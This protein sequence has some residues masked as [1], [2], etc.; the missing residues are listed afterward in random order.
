MDKS[1]KLGKNV[2]FHKNVK[3]GMNSI[4]GNN[5]ELGIND[6]ELIIGENSTIRSYSI[7]Y[8]DVKIGN[9][10]TTG[11]RIMIREKTTIGESVIIGTNSIIDGNCQIGNN[12]SIQSGVY[13]TW[14]V[15]VEDNVFMGPFSKTTNDKYPP[16][17]DKSA[18][19]GPVLKKGCSIG[20]GAI[21]LPGIEI[22]E[23]T[24]IGAGSIVTK[25]IPPNV[26]AFGN[27]CKVVKEL[28]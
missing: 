20:S 25:N 8:G 13:V 9:R 10:F 12:V 23:N 7:I 27:P 18:L 14:G 6:N 21:I 11:H 1:I 15:K 28:K 2:I 26:I 24:L 19:I 22:G 16:T 5:V 4:I 17:R 3:I